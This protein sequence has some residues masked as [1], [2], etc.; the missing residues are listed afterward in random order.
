MLAAGRDITSA[1]A[2]KVRLTM[3][4]ED[5]GAMMGAFS[6]GGS[7]DRGSMNSVIGDCRSSLDGAEKTGNSC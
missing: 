2:R 6:F 7:V 3:T 4:G 1:I 5:G